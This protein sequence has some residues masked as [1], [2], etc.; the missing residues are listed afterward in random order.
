[1]FSNIIST[2]YPGITVIDR[3]KLINIFFIYDT[4]T[5]E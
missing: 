1:M 4:K 2:Y 3:M 5:K